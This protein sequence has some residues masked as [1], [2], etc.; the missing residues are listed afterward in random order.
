MAKPTARGSWLVSIVC[1]VGLL[2]SLGGAVH[3]QTREQQA[4]IRALN[5]GGL[6]QVARVQADEI[7]RCIQDRADGSL[8]GQIEDCFTAD[9][10]GRVERTLGRTR[11]RAARQCTQPPDFGPANAEVV[12]QVALETERTLV[13]QV[14]GSDLDATIVTEAVDPQT[15][16][17]QQ[18]VFEAVM[19][20]ERAQLREFNR[21]KSKG[22][23]DGWVG[24]AGSLER[25]FVGLDVPVLRIRR[26]CARETGTIRR[27]IDTR[28][29]AEGVDLAVAFP[30]CGSNDPAEVAACLKHRAACRA[31]V[32]L[33][34]A[35]GLAHD[36]DASDDGSNN[37]TCI[38]TGPFD[39]S[40]GNGGFGSWINDEFELPAY[41]YTGCAWESCADPE[42]TF[43]QLGNDDITAVAHADGYVELFTVET[44]YRYAN[45]YDDA[46]GDFGGGFGWVRDGND[47]WSTLYDDRPAGSTYERIYG[48]GYYR[49][50]VEHGGLR[51]RQYVY[52]AAGG[53]EVLLERLV[54]TNLS[55]AEKTV[56]YF[57]YW[58]VAW[59]LV[60]ASDD[61]VSASRYD[62]ATVKTF[63]D[64][65]RA[66]IKA[67]S[68]APAG[69]PEVPNLVEDPSPKVSFVTFLGDVPDRFETV[70]T[71]FLGSG[72]RALPQA[73]AAGQLGNSLDATGS[74]PSREAVLATQKDFSLP[75]GESRTLDV[76]YGLSAR[77]EE[78][79]LID[80]FRAA[81]A[82][83][84]PEIAAD[85]GERIPR[86]QLPEKTWI[87]R[88][89]A[90]SYYY[91][92]SGLLREDF[93]E[94]RVLNQ[95]S[96]YQYGWGAN[97]G[98]RAAL[99]HL[100]PLVYMNPEIA[101]EILIYYLRAMKPTGELCYATAGYG[102]W[103]SLG[104]LPSDHSLWLLLALVEYTNATRDWAF[105]D[106]TFDY[107]CEAG[108]G[109]CGSATAYDM[110]KRAYEYQR[111][112]VTT[113]ANGLVRLLDSDWDDFLTS[114][115][116]GVDPVETKAN[117]ESTMN[118]ALA[119][120][121]YP[122]FADLAERRGDTAFAASVRQTA[123]DLRGPMRAQWRGDFFNRAWVYSAPGVP[124]EVG[125][126]N[127][128]LASNGPALLVDGLMTP[129]ELERLVGRMRTD[130]SD[131]SPGG[132][133]SQGAPIILLQGTPGQWY[134]LSGPTI[135][136]LWRHPEIAGARELAWLEFTKQTFA[137]HAEVYPYI[138]YGIW[139]GPDMYFT[140]IDAVPG[141]FAE[142]E[143]WCFPGVLCMQDFPVTNM[144]SHSEP[145][146][147]SVRMAGAAVDDAG[148]TIDPGF[149]FANFRWESGS[150]AVEYTDAT[151]GGRLRALGD[152]TIEMRVRLPVSLA[153]AAVSVEV[154][155]TSVPFTIQDGFAVFDMPLA[156]GVTSTWAVR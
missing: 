98:P 39:T 43:H 92:I 148:H 82:W 145:L 100:L 11:R 128:F 126:G 72:D 47:T 135:E 34:Q 63:H 110:F 46:L 66:T 73:V 143:T 149:P 134:S 127:L 45:K 28:C 1:V 123:D 35:D 62:P 50:Q 4:C 17:C 120:A 20:C 132:L 31:C 137:N 109:L 3:A 90:W 155:G 129:A 103:N 75:P 53:D 57:D 124:L 104:F 68:Q 139:S 97:A 115:S 23:K 114:V 136:G 49:K 81:T 141:L 107:Y 37:A 83:S 105:L 94:T 14:F 19:R 42:D 7:S 130:C 22:L 24:N 111:D 156:A 48:M 154:G 27:R 101:R 147:S 117:G 12:I 78:D 77:G 2:G 38:G 5:R 32:A 59:W 152:D 6:Q 99:R 151:A 112:V 121:A 10:R 88:E 95:G 146:F 91:L 36:C 69:D 60:L 118:T 142:G 138:W 8:S 76:L 86:L 61:N 40:Y 131:P 113:G 125:A 29:V 119:L 64:P 144:F 74:L 106:E 21:C 96:L 58:D 140:P 13:R 54:F 153:P 26:S 18:R 65:A 15:S 85:W 67:V 108:R 89:M 116:V 30:G 44:Y 55:D 122:L 84:L 80:R 79:A 56:S 150:Y 33:N 25:C 133:A 70:Q 16:K 51:V 52:P 41:L 87:A 102:A 71:D 9:A 93:F